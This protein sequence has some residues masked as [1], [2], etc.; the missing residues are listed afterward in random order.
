MAKK[1]KSLKME[2]G[3][4]NKQKTI[5]MNS[6]FYCFFEIKEYNRMSMKE[7]DINAA[8]KSFI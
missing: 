3:R 1:S 7:G 2:I 4:S 8:C 6:L 5:Q